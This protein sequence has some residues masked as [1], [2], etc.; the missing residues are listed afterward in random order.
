MART[1][2]T[3][4]VQHHG[5]TKALTRILRLLDFSRDGY[6]VEQLEYTVEDG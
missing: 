6:G 4:T 3:V 5:A 2:I 1:V